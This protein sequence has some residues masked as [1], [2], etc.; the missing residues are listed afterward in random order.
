[1][2]LQKFFAGRFGFPFTLKREDL[3]LFSIAAG[4]QQSRGIKRLQARAPNP[5][6]AAEN[7]AES[8]RIGA[9]HG[10]HKVVDPRGG[11]GPVDR[12]VFGAAPAKRGGGGMVLWNSRRRAGF[13]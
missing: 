3:E 10:A 4:D 1:M 12:P 9:R 8:A 6:F 13:Q 11:P 7:F 5:G 2:S